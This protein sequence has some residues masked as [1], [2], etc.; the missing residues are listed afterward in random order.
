LREKFS[1]RFIPLEG[2]VKRIV[3]SEIEDKL[4]GTIASCN[5][6]KASDNWLGKYS[7]IPQIKNGSYGFHNI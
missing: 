1:F 3:R 6:C 2:Q 4:I 7:P 5:F